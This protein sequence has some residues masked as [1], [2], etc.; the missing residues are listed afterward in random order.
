MEKIWLVVD[1]IVKHRT[2]GSFVRIISPVQA[3]EAET[4]EDMKNF[5]KSVFPYLNEYIPS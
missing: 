5:I 2:D 1:A 3:N 4:V